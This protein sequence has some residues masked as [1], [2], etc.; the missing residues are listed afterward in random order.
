MKRGTVLGFALAPVVDAGA[1]AA[2]PQ[3][4]LNLEGLGTLQT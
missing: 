2:S 1:G 3:N 4:G